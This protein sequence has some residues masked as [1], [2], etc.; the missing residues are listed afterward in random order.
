MVAMMLKDVSLGIVM[1]CW[2][3]MLNLWFVS[4]KINKSV[5][6]SAGNGTRRERGWGI[7]NSSRQVGKYLSAV[8]PVDLSQY[9]QD[10]HRSFLSEMGLL[11][12]VIE[13]AELLNH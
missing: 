4:V 11:I 7:V 5:A 2:M 6:V 12:F 3:F 10:D 1:R 8:P 9:F 13:A